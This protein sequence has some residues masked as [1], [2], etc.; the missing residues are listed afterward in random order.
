MSHMFMVGVKSNEYVVYLAPPKAPLKSPAFMVPTADKADD[1]SVQIK[2]VSIKL[3]DVQGEPSF[4][5]PVIENTKRLNELDALL[6]QPIMEPP[7]K[8]QKR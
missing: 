1:A 8:K 6:L 7:A 5:M 3:A 2:C 4:Q